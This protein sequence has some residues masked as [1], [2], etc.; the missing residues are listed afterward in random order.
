M[1]GAVE[2]AVDR[3]E[4]EGDDPSLSGG[5]V[6]DGRAALELV[7]ALD[8]P[9]DEH[10]DLVLPG[11]FLGL[12]LLL[13]QGLQGLGRIVLAVF[14]PELRAPLQNDLAPLRSIDI[15]DRQHRPETDVTS[16]MP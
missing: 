6:Q 7:I 10:L 1:V 16:V 12:S 3:V 11:L 2:V 8:G 13:R 14:L 9:A 5:E 4:V 15:V